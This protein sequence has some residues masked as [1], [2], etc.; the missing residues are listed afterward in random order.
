VTGLQQI[1]PPA[2][3]V[4]A[5]RFFGRPFTLRLSAR[6]IE[7]VIE[8]TARTTVRVEDSRLLVAQALT[9][10]VEKAGIYAIELSPL[11]GFT[12]ADVKGDGIEDW[13]VADNKLK[14]TF[15]SRLLGQRALEVRLERAITAT[16][17]GCAWVSRPRTSGD[18]RSPGCR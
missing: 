11:A 3:A 16:R 2:G 14:I 10:Q 6:R 15:G 4:A 13:R 1:N 18:R 7:P 5:Y 8:T 17:R 12:V 9:L